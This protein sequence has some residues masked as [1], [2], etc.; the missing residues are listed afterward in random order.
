MTS[1]VT[2]AALG[3]AEPLL[4]ALDAANYEI[5]TPIQHKAIPALLEGRDMMGLAQTGTG[6][7]AAFALPI[8]QR[9][10]A[11]RHGAG[12]KGT[13]ALILAPTRELAIQID[14]SF[15]TYGA[16]LN[17]RIAVVYGG[18]SQV[19][20]VKAL[21]DVAPWRMAVVLEVTDQ[22][23]RIGFQP[24]RE[25]GGA[26]G[27]ERE[28]GTLPLEHI[29]EPRVKYAAVF[30]PDQTDKPLFIPAPAKVEPRLIEQ[31]Q[32]LSLTAASDHVPLDEVSRDLDRLSHEAQAASQPELVAAVEHA[33]DAIAHSHNTEE[34]AAAREQLAQQLAATHRLAA[35]LGD[36]RHVVPALQPAFD[37]PGG[38]AVTDVIE[39]G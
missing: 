31:A 8:L 11:K 26:L 25:P 1:E 2:F 21:S 36:Q 39:E 4:R 3:L 22:S 37:V 12:A 20:Q 9:L 27:K 33:K 23:A 29:I 13:R 35:P 14:E 6:K 24:A 19:P 17:F 30:A 28:I 32:S 18:V 10:S 7:T 15:R 5:P 38:E 16:H 34:V